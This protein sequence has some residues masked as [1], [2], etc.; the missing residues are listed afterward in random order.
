MAK[1]DKDLKKRMK[2]L[3]KS[4]KKAAKKEKKLT[5]KRELSEF[6]KNKLKAKK[7]SKK[8]AKI[9]KKAA[10]I[11][12]EKVKDDIKNNANT[13]Y[14]REK[15]GMKRFLRS[16]NI[17]ESTFLGLIVNLI[18]SVFEL[19][20]GLI[21]GSVAI[22]SDSIHDFGDAISLGFSIFFGRKAKR[23]PDKTYT[24]GYSRFSILGVFV[25]TVILVVGASFMIYVSILRFI[26]PADVNPFI[27]MVLSI[28]GLIINTFVAFRTENGRFNVIRAI[29]EKSVNGIILEDVIGWF[30]VLIGSIIMLNT[31]WL[32]LDPL[33][34]IIISVYLIG[35]S[36]NSF[37]KVLS[38]FLEKVPDGSSVDI[39]KYQV[40][41]IP[42]VLNVHKVHLW[43]MDGRKL[44]ATMHVVVDGKV[45]DGVLI[46]NS[47]ENPM[48]IKKE[49]RK[50]LKTTG[51][52][53]VTIEIESE[54]EKCK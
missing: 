23:G 50:Q 32:W 1:V 5:P 54:N 51:V 15:R 11:N 30:A 24:Y 39:V 20:G 14:G 49:I 8:A 41:A 33:M 53:E 45:I 27:M 28:V 16:Q 38:L 43:S 6:R 18:F 19:V 22:I 2:A 47:V 52:N 10:K 12:L 25:T 3:E 44:C 17:P 13:V 35:S 4:A 48:N 29:S 7:A 42:H 46:E 40:L 36:F 31:G 37:K 26:E 34:S 21:S 9:N